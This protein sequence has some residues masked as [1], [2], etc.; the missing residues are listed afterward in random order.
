M[1]AITL[2]CNAL[3]M[4]QRKEGM[5]ES[6]MVKCIM[7]S[8]VYFKTSASATIPCNGVQFDIGQ[9]ILPS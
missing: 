4:S 7:F 2:N 8:M 6:A 1:I 5:E 9:G 3:K